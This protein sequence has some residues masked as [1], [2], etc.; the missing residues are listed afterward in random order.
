[1]QV[2]VVSLMLSAALGAEVQEDK[3]S[4][5]LPMLRK[6]A[7][8]ADAFHPVAPLPPPSAV[9]ARAGAVVAKAPEETAT[10]RAAILSTAQKAA[11]LAALLPAAAQAEYMSKEDEDKQALVLAIISGIVLLA[12]ITGIQMA[13]GAIDKM[14]SEDDERFRGD[15]DPRNFRR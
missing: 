11:G 6:L 9:A 10:R 15:N 8:Q 1:M 7:V 12:P 14:A 13:R 2:L 3:E 5:R 4:P